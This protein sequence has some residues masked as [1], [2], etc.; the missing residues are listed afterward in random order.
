M[1]SNHP[2]APAHVTLLLGQLAAVQ[3][4]MSRVTGDVRPQRA[5]TFPAVVVSVG[6]PR[7]NWARGCAAVGRSGHGAHLSAVGRVVV[8]RIEALRVVWEGLVGGTR[9]ERELSRSVRSR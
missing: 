9:D 5:E 3:V 6:P 8:A 7:R 4:R 1:G 2:L